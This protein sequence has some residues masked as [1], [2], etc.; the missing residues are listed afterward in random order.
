[1]KLKQMLAMSLV[2]VASVAVA[3]G[4]GPIQQDPA[5]RTGKL[6]NGLTY[7]VMHNDYPE[8]RVNFYIAQRVGSLQEEESQRGLAHFLE[9]MAFN[10][11]TN[12]P[13]NGVI[14]YTR[15][16]GVEFG[17]DLNAYTSVDQTVYNIND[18]PSTRVEALDSCLLILKD[19]SNGL[20]LEGEEIDKER[21]VIH[22]EWRLRLTASQRMFERNL[23]TLYPGSKYGLR[24]PIGLMSV[25]D[26]FKH[27]ELRDY[28]HKWYRPDNQAIIVVGDIDVDRTEAKIKELFSPIELQEGAAQVVDE[29]VPDNAEPIIVVDKDKEQPYSIVQLMFK[30]EP[31]PTELK[32]DMMYMLIQYGN[33]MIESMLDARMREKAQEPDCPYLQAGAGDDNYIFSKTMDAFTIGVLPKP[34]QTE[35]ALQAALVEAIR[36]AKYGFTESEYLRA[37]EEYLSRLEDR[38]NNRDKVNNNVF[39]R[40]MASNYLEQEPLTSIEFDYQILSQLAPNIP[41]DIANELISGYV[42]M[43]DSNM[44]VLNFNQELE[45]AVYPTVE[46]LKAAIDNARSLDIEPYVD[47]VKNE[48][49]MSVLPKPGKIVKEVKSDKFDYTELTLSNGVKVILKPTDFK[50]DEI[51]MLAESKGGT[52]LYGEADWVNCQVADAAVSYGGLGNFNH[53]ELEKALAGKQA[54]VNLSLST[55]YERLNGESTI[56]DLETLFQLTYLTMTDVRKDEKAFNSLMGQLETILKNKHLQ[57]EGVFSDSLEL[58]LNNHSWRERPFDAEHVKQV[59]LDR[60]LEI[61]RERMA[62]AADFTFY[63]IGSFDNDTI[64]KYICQYIAT[65]P[66][67]PKKH[68]N[69]VNVMERPMGK[70]VNQFTNKSETP[71]AIARMYWFN[72][73]LPYTLENKIILDAAGQV[74]DKLYLQKIREDAGAAYTTTVRGY[75]QRVGDRVFSTI[76]GHCPMNPDKSDL[77]IGLMRDEIVSIADNVD[78][79]TLADIK[80]LM[81]KDHAGNVK[82]N[83]Y[84]LNVI[85]SW[86]GIGYDSE[87]DYVNIVNALTPEQVSAFVK[88]NILSTGNVIE[89]I[90]LPEE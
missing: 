55:S 83:E 26:N 1:M 16:L 67:N 47:N 44:V 18:V 58:T 64:R 42:S 60:A 85:S 25:V 79:A 29:P 3:Q 77:A 65:L 17:R 32:G 75:N 72:T 38:Y 76:L 14:D 88:N 57:P 87:T 73:E 33:D 19:W 5:V 27:Q 80:E 35:A 56:K 13:G 39:G 31:L 37:R 10:G 4:L 20:L 68:E 2:A 59:N 49:L 86:V 89:V 78:V 46:S 66:A 24:M 11:T 63:F 71:K 51:K 48:P 15:T 84:W 8:H 52:S 23:E 6:D 82:E 40:A 21:G 41:V 30:H 9:H 43:S 90:M 53:T 62:N 7:Y 81:L 28:Y 74:L 36:A 34:G 54:S 12:F 61:A 50:A 45:G 70:T 22:E 69:Y